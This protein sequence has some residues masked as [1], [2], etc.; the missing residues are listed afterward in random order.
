MK[1]RLRKMPSHMLYW[2]CKCTSFYGWDFTP[3]QAFARWK[4]AQ[5]R[6]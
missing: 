6:V 3:E 2:E 4:E 5:Q 1:P